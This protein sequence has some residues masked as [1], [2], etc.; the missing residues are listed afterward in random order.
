MDR[1]SW[2]RLMGASALAFGPLRAVRAAQRP[3]RRVVV[4]GAG[5]LGAG[6]GY[7]LA[8]RGA[9]V[10]ILEKRAPASGATGDSFAYL[11][12]STKASA[13][14]PYFD[15]NWRGIAG[16]HAWQREPG[17][18]LPL[19][20]SGSVYWRDEREASAQLLA[21][22]ETVRARGYRSERLD[23]ARIRS[24][25]PGVANVD[26]AAVGALYEEEGA[27]DPVGAVEALLARA[28]A[29]GAELV[30]PV[31]VT[32][33]LQSRGRVVGV[34]TGRGEVHADTVVVAAGLGSRALA[35][36]VD[37]RLPLTSSQ[38]ILLHTAPQPRLL[39]RIVFAPGSTFRQTLDGRIVSSGGHE[40]TGAAGA[41]PDEIGRRIL[42]GAARY[43][44]GIGDA[45]ID[46]V[47]VGERVIPADTLPVVGFAPRVGQLYLGVTHSG[48]TLAP[49]IARFAAEEILQGVS[50]EPLDSFRPQRFET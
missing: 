20:W 12:A 48:I 10:T 26:D 44:P 25:L 2:L 45:A 4:I 31:V 43:L 8:K 24:L 30:H 46:R 37:V 21:T 5:I 22:L 29:H 16:W 15:L 34:R 40:G 41:D 11:N 39:E 17:A 1:R 33:L 18:A 28:R 14:R 35:E 3:A 9:E 23:A 42:A 6:I 38:G 7:E 19:S 47:S 27:V 49:A 32:G 13:P 50:L 36:S